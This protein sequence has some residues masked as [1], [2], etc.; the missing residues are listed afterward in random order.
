M[1]DAAPAGSVAA[2]RRIRQLLVDERLRR[3]RTEKVRPIASIAMRR[4][5]RKAEQHCAQQPSD[6]GPCR[7][8][9]IHATKDKP[10]HQRVH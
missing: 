8:R 7:G 1:E 9:T 4:V 10:A 6:A 2:V 5:N 3:R